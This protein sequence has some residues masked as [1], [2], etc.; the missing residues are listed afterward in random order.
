M[1]LLSAG[2]GGH[3]TLDQVR[4]HFAQRVS[5][6]PADDEVSVDEN[7]YR[8]ALAH[9][10]PKTIERLTGEIIRRNLAENHGKKVKTLSDLKISN[11]IL[12]SMLKK[13]G[14]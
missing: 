12:Y 14:G 6:G 11:R 4:R 7:W 5:G 9:G 13:S 2:G 10:L 1:E 8:Y 3:V